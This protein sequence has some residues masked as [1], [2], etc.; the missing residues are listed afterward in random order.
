MPVCNGPILKLRTFMG[1]IQLDGESGTLLG[2]GEF[3]CLCLKLK[4]LHMKTLAH[5]Y[6]KCPPSLF[7]TAEL[8]SKDHHRAAKKQ[9]RKEPNPDVIF[10][11]SQN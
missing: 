1:R 10:C 4:H 9:Q 2:I 11:F 8:I 5:T 7:A 3:I 6:I